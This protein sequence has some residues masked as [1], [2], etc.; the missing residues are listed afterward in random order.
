MGAALDLVPGEMEGY[1]TSPTG[2]PSNMQPA[3]AVAAEHGA[4]GADEAWRIFS[5]RPV[6]PDY[7]EE[8]QF[9]IVPVRR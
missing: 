5:T 8:P 9:A 3:L 1:S 2:Y 6:Q 4:T 7:R